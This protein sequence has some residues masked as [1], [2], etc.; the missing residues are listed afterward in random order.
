M[1]AHPGAPTFKDERIKEKYLGALEGT[2]YYASH[3]P[4][5]METVEKPHHFTGR[6]LSFWDSLFPR[7]SSSS[8]SSSMTT[9]PPPSFP[10]P[11]QDLTVLVT[12]HGG[13]IKVLVPA[14]AKERGIR[15]SPE[16]LRAAQSIKYK[17]WNCSI[18]EVVCTLEQPPSSQPH[19][20]PL[21]RGEIKRCVRRVSLSEDREGLT[22]SKVERS[23]SAPR[24]LSDVSCY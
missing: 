4:E 3:T 7:P 10:L 13:P 17:V 23:G 22:R 14:L 11:P 9:T 20:V 1:Q 6:L 8:S 16:A 12:S 5:V 18:S 19:S 2:I 24:H 15:W 21:W